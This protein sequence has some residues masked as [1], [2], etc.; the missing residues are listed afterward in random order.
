MNFLKTIAQKMGID[1]AIAYSSGARVI[2]SGSGVLLVLLIAS[3]LSAEE[4]GYYFTFNSV[5][6]IQ[7]FFELGFTTIITQLVAHEVSHLKELDD[8]TYEGETYYKSRL[9]SLLHF[10]LKW[11]GIA[12]VLFLFIVVIFGLFFFRGSDDFVTWKWPWVLI[13]ISTAIKMFQSPV[14]AILMGL[15]KVTEMNRIVFYQQLVT[16]L[17]LCIGL[18][19]GMKLYVLGI[20]SIATIIIWFVYVCKPEILSLLVNVFREPI[21]EKV[22]YIKEIF[23]YQWRIALSSLSGYFIFY[24]LTPILFQF[25]GAI[26]AG[27][28]GLTISIISAIQAMSMS[29]LN[30]KTPLYSRL[31][32]LKQFEELD[33]IFG[34]T[35]KQMLTICSL[36]MIVTIIGLSIIDYTNLSLGETEIAKRFLTGSSLFF[37][38]IAYFSDQFTFSWASYLRCHKKEP[39]LVLSIV[40][41]LLCLTAVYFTAQF[42]SITIVLFFYMIARISTVPWGYVIFNRCKYQWHKL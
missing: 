8:H 34:K 5:L 17:V 25:Q 15:D 38:M 32:A 18:V 36:L 16:P 29:W 42:F 2:Q 13:S 31:I 26:I 1:K 37:L 6:S 40:S 9:S 22:N 21:L 33:R 27:Q 41:G 19:C 39:Y 30:T 11:Y 4:Q 10:S 20:S 12:S 35:M 24:F 7:V 23:P 28:V 3:F 14:T